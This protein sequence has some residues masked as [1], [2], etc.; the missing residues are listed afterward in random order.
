[1]K[2]PETP[3]VD[4]AAAVARVEQDSEAARVVALVRRFAEIICKGSAHS[5]VS[6]DEFMAAFDVWLAEATSCGIRTLGFLDS[7]LTQDGAAVRSALIT[8]W[9]NAQA[10]WQINKL[11]L[12]M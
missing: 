10:E 1:M 6:R 4:E 3:A 9:S 5:S 2:A 8:P 12:L 7:G 11:K